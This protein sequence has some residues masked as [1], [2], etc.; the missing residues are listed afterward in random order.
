MQ[1]EFAKLFESEEL[2]QILV[3]RRVAS[4]G[5]SEVR[6]TFSC[7]GQ[8]VHCTA[9]CIDSNG[10]PVDDATNEGFVDSMFDEAT[11]EDAEAIVLTFLMQVGSCEVSH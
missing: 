9:Q 5:M 2:G 11:L 7:D 6:F 4:N 1:R 10:D 3:V 8:L